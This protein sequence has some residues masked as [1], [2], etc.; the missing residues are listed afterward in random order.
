MLNQIKEDTLVFLRGQFLGEPK[1]YEH[2]EKKLKEELK[3]QSKTIA[4]EIQIKIDQQILKA[5]QAQFQESIEDKVRR[6]CSSVS[7]LD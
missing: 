3:K 4:K 6:D 2:F 1:Q 5:I 7:T